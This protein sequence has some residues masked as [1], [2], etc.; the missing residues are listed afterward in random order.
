MGHHPDAQSALAALP[1]SIFLPPG[2]ELREV[3]GDAMA[4]T[5]RP[6]EWVIVDTMHRVAS[7]PGIYEISNDAGTE[8]VFLEAVGGRPVQVRLWRDN[9]RYERRELPA[10]DI[11]IVG[12]VVGR[13]RPL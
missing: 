4:P 1:A 6:S 11:Q 5:L 12:R 9:P 10:S 13:W 7:P 2:Q 3:K 8:F